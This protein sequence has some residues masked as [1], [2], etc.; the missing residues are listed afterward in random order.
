[1]DPEILDAGDLAD[2]LPGAPG[3]EAMLSDFWYFYFPGS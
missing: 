1:M 2:I 3:L